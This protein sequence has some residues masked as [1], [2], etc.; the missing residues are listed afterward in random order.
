M[1]RIR[2]DGGHRHR[3]RQVGAVIGLVAL[4]GAGGWIAG[5]QMQSTADA[6]ASHQPPEAKPVTVPVTRQKL[7]ATVVT[8]GSVEFGA[9]HTVTL[10]G[11][12]G[13][14]AASPDEANA[15]LVTKL[16]MEG[17]TLKEGSVLMQVSGSASGYWPSVPVDGRRMLI[18]C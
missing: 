9:P 3:T 12:V 4:V 10:S 17:A 2:I 8:Q 6:A 11:S 13:S 7:T 1:N 18:E 15:Q 14:S 16:P 5:T